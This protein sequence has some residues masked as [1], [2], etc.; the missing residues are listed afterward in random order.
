M[1]VDR[2]KFRSEATDQNLKTSLTILQ[3]Q[4][5]TSAQKEFA[6]MF[7]LLTRGNTSQL[8]IPTS[9]ASRAMLDTAQLGYSNVVRSS[10]EVLH[11]FKRDRGQRS[12]VI[13]QKPGSLRSGEALPR[14]TNI[15]AISL[16]FPFYLYPLRSRNIGLPR[17]FTLLSYFL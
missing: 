6:F 12:W 8:N 10:H 13:L 16:K 15:S 2:D 3:G 1:E 11:R 5:E 9:H 4:L 7:K 14:S 17:L